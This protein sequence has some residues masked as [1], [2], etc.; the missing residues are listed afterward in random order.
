M[1]PCQD[2]ALDR[3]P[4]PADGAGEGTWSRLTRAGRTVLPR[5][6]GCELAA[7]MRCSAGHLLMLTYDSPYDEGLH[8][9][10]LDDQD[11]LR[12][13]LHVG[14]LYPDGI[15]LVSDL[16]PQA[17]DTLEFDFYGPWRLRVTPHPGL[18]LSNTPH[19]VR[20][21]LARLL[22]RHFLHLQSLGR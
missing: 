8:L 12:D 9:L 14:F 22:G 21:P 20:R 10:Y 6:D 1:Q 18:R 19:G 4:E 7:Q 5:V 13:E 3:L 17:D 2:F 11:S 15:G 16:R